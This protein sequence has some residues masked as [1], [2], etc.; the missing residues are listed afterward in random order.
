MSLR[1]LNANQVLLLH[2]PDSFLVGFVM[3]PDVVHLALGDDT[4]VD[5]A[6]RTQVVE[7]AG[8]DGVSHQLLGLGLLQRDKQHTLEESRRKR[9]KAA[10]PLV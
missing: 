4:Q 7:D 9:S 8:S 1:L 10:G 3:G 2:S 6:A 5:V